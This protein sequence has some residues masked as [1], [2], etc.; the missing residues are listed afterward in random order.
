MSPVPSVPFVEIYIPNA[1]TEEEFL[2]LAVQ[3]AVKK[4]REIHHPPI[5][6]PQTICADGCALPQSVR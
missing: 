6:L 5:V 4:Y 1:K 2:L 3:A